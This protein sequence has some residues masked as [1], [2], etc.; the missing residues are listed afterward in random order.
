MMMVMGGTV[1]V[2]VP[3]IQV[4]MIRV[5]MI[6]GAIRVFGEDLPPGPCRLAL[7]PVFLARKIFVPTDYHVNLSCANA[8]AADAAHFQAGSQ[9][10]GCNGLLQQSQGHA[11]VNQHAEKH[12]AADPGKAIKISYAHNKVCR[13]ASV[14]Q[15]GNAAGGAGQGVPRIP[16]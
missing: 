12:V 6:R 9:V 2:R 14:Y 10:E 15:P 8:A 5:L 3:V 13:N 7:C 16:L 4:S 11:G 1:L